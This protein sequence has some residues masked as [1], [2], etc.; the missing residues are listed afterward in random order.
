[1][2]IKHSLLR[3]ILVLAFIIVSYLVFSK[4]SYSQN[5]PQ[6]DKVGHMG[7]FLCLSFLTYL[8]FRPKWWL[9]CATMAAYGIF[10]ELVQA[11]LPYRSADVADFAADMV[12]VGFFYF[13]LW[14]YRKYFTAA[15]LVD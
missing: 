3:I 13:C 6:L 11:R 12:G 10:I 8:A 7:S 9:L 15:Y 14:A 5:I 4:P 1:V 2:I